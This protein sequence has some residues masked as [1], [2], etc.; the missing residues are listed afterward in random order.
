[1]VFMKKKST[2]YKRYCGLKVDMTTFIRK[3]IHDTS[4]CDA[5]AMSRTII[6]NALVLII[7]HALM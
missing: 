3:N 2:S 5:M 1:M 7:C 6:W 4:Y